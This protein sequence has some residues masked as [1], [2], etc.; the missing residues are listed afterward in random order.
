[1]ENMLN[2]RSK[3]GSGPLEEFNA[4][5]YPYRRNVAG[6]LAL[7]LFSIYSALTTK[8]PIPQFMPSA[9]L[10]HLRMINKVREV[11]M[12]A[13]LEDQDDL[14]PSSTVEKTGE[15]RYTDIHHLGRQRAVR[16]KYLSWNATSAAQQEIIEYLEELIDLT[17][18]L[19]GAN[20]FRS[21]LFYRANFQTSAQ[22]PLDGA[23]DSTT[24]DAGHELEPVLSPISQGDDDTTGA[25]DYSRRLRRRRTTMLSAG[26]DG[27]ADELPASLMRIQTRKR[28]AGRRRASTKLRAGTKDV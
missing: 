19:V 2:L 10:A 26:G 24:D 25:M 17:K 12:E 18:L 5:L 13:P 14:S 23:A 22:A 7:S 3:Y 16:R 21:G 9:R 20:E 6:C 11:V 4:Q 15:V 8:L 27:A 28:E 1:M